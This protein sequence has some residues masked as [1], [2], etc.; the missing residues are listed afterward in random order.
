MILDKNGVYV[1]NDLI[2]QV[3]NTKDFNQLKR[4][5]L[6]TLCSLIPVAC[7]TIYESRMDGGGVCNLVCVPESYEGLRDAYL[8]RGS[9]DC[10]RWLS[11]KK[12]FVIVTSSTLLA[13]SERINTGLYRKCY[14]PYAVHYSLYMTIASHDEYLGILVLYKR[15]D[16]GDFTTKEKFI[17][18]ILSEHLNSRFYHQRYGE[19]PIAINERRRQEYTAFYGMTEREI[20]VAEL[21]SKGRSNDEICEILVISRNTLKKH[22]QHI[23]RK[24]GVNSRS[25]LVAILA[26]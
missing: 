25:Q 12:H 21:L 18:E 19:F 15:K 16:Q 10:C 23:Y 17:L 22:L 24:V 9:T 1:L 2:Y 13:E 20:D 14:E 26:I 4:D 11:Q 3:Y 8:Y 6:E 5:F 7:G